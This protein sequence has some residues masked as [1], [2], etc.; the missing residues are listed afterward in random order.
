MLQRSA[1]LVDRL[2]KPKNGGTPDPSQIQ[3]H[4]NAAF[5]ESPGR[6]RSPLSPRQ[7]QNVANM[8]SRS[9]RSPRTGGGSPAR[10]YKPGD[11]NVPSPSQCGDGEEGGGTP[12]SDPV[13]QQQAWG[14]G[15]FSR[16]VS[17][18]RPST[19]PQNAAIQDSQLKSPILPGTRRLP[20]WNP[21]P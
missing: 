11:L 20:I 14:A 7:G 10:V 4:Q 3:L 19:R 16:P 8:G 18:I 12:V 6:Q 17:P 9:P 15:R 13:Q 21:G 5:E 2:K 1:E